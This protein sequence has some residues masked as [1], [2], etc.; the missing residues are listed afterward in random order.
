MASAMM[1]ATQGRTGD[2]LADVAEIASLLD[3]RLLLSLTA[4][5]YAM[6]RDL[7]LATRIL[8]IARDAAEERVEPGAAA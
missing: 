2:L 6:V 7:T 1:H 3:R 5:Q 4:E 8:A